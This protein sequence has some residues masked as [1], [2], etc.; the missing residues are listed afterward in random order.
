MGVVTLSMQQVKCPQEQWEAHPIGPRCLLVT[1]LFPTVLMFWS[2]LLPDGCH[3]AFLLSSDKDDFR[4]TDSHVGG[5]STK[6]GNESLDNP[7]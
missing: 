1:K 4:S 3:L 2:I 5:W 6:D 7:F